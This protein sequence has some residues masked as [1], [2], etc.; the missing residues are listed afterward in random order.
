[1]NM[2]QDDYSPIIVA[3]C[4][5]HRVRVPLRE[6]FRISNG[7]V[8]EKEAILV[9]LNTTRGITGGGEASPM[10]GSFYSADTPESTWRALAEQLIPLVFARGIDVPRFYERL[11]A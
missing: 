3:R 8:A 5:L 9:E 7:E 4:V 1:M 11:R 10:S 6:P 2:A